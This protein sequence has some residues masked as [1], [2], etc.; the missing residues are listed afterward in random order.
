M[1]FNLLDEALANLR[2][3]KLTLREVNPKDKRSRSRKVYRATHNMLDHMERSIDKYGPNWLDDK[4]VMKELPELVEYTSDLADVPIES[5]WG[6][7]RFA[8]ELE[9][10]T[11]EAS[12]IE[13]SPDTIYTYIYEGYTDRAEVNHKG[14]IDPD[15]MFYVNSVLKLKQYDLNGPAK[16]VGAYNVLHT[17]TG[18]V[19]E[20][21]TEF[22]DKVNLYS[23]RPEDLNITHSVG[24][25]EHGIFMSNELIDDVTSSV[26]NNPYS[27][28]SKSMKA[29]MVSKH[30]SE[31][32]D[33][34]F[35]IGMTAS[36]FVQEDSLQLNPLFALINRGEL[37]THA[38]FSFRT[39]VEILPTMKRN[40]GKIVNL[41]QTGSVNGERVF[42]G[43]STKTLK[44]EARIAEKFVDLMMEYYSKFKIETLI[45]K[46]TNMTKTGEVITKPLRDTATLRINVANPMAFVSLFLEAINTMVFPVVSKN[47]EVDLD[48]AVNITPV[49]T[50]IRVKLYNRPVESYNITM[51]TSSLTGGVVGD[52]RDLDMAT[53]TL[54]GMIGELL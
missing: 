13:G 49:V 2:P 36:A 6:S 35:D 4:K 53:K 16:L 37:E 23:M 18:S 30:A 50:N 17:P 39:L 32:T 14:I 12:Y 29:Q 3:F 44:P 15:T 48:I 8:F 7:R 46:S 33:D 51:F 34:A 25:S 45:F 5:G 28:L 41:F 40:Y 47:G 42:D 10:K 27:I 20:N 11:K 52:E 22:V 1:G 9:L 26:S 21:D 24:E 19:L 43:T 54:S 31:I 38:S